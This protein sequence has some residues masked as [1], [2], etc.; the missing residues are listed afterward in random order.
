MNE[1]II[2]AKLRAFGTPV[3]TRL[4]VAAGDFD[5]HLHDS[6]DGKEH[7]VL[8]MGDVRGA[9]PVLVRVHSE[10]FTGDVLGSRRCDCG[11]Q[12]AEALARIAHEGRGVLIYLR[13]EG[14]GIGLANKL[15][16]YNLQDLGFDT[17]DAN[18]ELG[19]AADARDYGIAAALLRELGVDAVRLLT[20]NPAKVAGLK[21]YGVDVCAREP[22]VIPAGPENRSYLDAKAKRMGHL[23][24]AP[25]VGS[26]LAPPAGAAELFAYLSREAEPRP[27]RPFVTLSYAQSLDGSSAAVGDRPLSIS[28]DPSRRFSH[29]VRA[30]HDA[31]LVGIGTVLADDPRLNV[32]DVP[33][34]DP[35]PIVIDS[36][37][38]FPLDARLLDHPTRQVWIATTSLANPERRRR[39]ESLGAVVLT[40]PGD[41]MNR[42][43]LELLF[44]Q[45][46]ERGV[47]KIMVE[48]GGRVLTQLM[49]ARL[50]DLLVLTVAPM[51]VG[52]VHAF[53]PPQGFS[54]RVQARI[55][56]PRYLQIGDDMIVW[57]APRWGVV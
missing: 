18:L 11:E 8:S 12:L 1:P 35:Q 10:C 23:L 2:D 24:D 16:A 26:K 53:T 38:R 44:A 41:D 27:E 19:H 7:L 50:V 49:T 30:A 43:D 15:R 20:N 4:P 40:V 54:T 55:E 17:V 29:H 42:V 52:G 48:G 32:R 21:A 13:Q 36:R 6:P 51:M 45:L 46:A 39:L 57:G 56:Q 34:V 22:L 14:R 5:V 37:L 25:A 31:I 9:G 3:S 28:C 47:R 33:G